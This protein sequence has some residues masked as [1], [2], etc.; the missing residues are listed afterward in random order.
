MKSLKK[1]VALFI[2]A[3]LFS[4]GAMPAL[5]AF[6][7]D[8][9]EFTGGDGHRY[10]IISEQ[11]KT[12]ALIGAAVGT[13]E[14]YNRE[15][16]WSWSYSG[17]TYDV[18]EIRLGVG[19]ANAEGIKNI[20]V[21]GVLYGRKK[22]TRVD[23]SGC[24][25]LV[26]LDC[27]LNALTELD[28]SSCTALVSLN[29]GGNALT[30]LDVSNCTALVSLD[31]GLNAL[32]ELDVS[33][34]K[35]L[36]YLSCAANAL[37]KLDVSENKALDYLWCG[38]NSIAELD[39]GG[40]GALRTLECERN[41]MTKLNMSGCM[42]LETLFCQDNSLKELDIVSGTKLINLTCS[43]NQLT[44]LDVS[45][46]TALKFLNCESN[47]IS[48]LDVST[49]INLTS[50][51]CGE[52]KLTSL[53]VTNNTSLGFLFCKSNAI[54]D[55]AG[56]VERMDAM[57]NF[58]TIPMVAKDGGYES[59]RQYELNKGSTIT[60][61]PS[62]GVEYDP[63]TKKF[64]TD[65]VATTVAFSTQNADYAEGLS[66]VS[67]V[68]S[69]MLEGEKP[70]VNPFA[71]VNE[72]DWFYPS[73]AFVVNNGLFNGTGATTFEPQG[74]MT[75]GSIVTVL[76]RMTGVDVAAYSGKSFDDVDM[77]VYYAPYIK[78]AAEKGIVNGTGNNKFEPDAEISRQDLSVILYNYI[79]K[80]GITIKQ[81]A[82]PRTGFYL[83]GIEEYARE[84]IVCLSG[85][86]IYGFKATDDF[87]PQG[88]ATR[89]EFAAM[90]ARYN[91]AI[92]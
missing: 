45:K 48:E 33:G 40:F 17:E 82:N 85:A 4:A 50:L 20:D 14:I 54:I 41:G 83:N 36:T 19:S 74:F 75:R 86:D 55:I 27:G 15:S 35:A 56:A 44:E 37:T 80:M 1:R 10:Q 52:N 68:I 39:V 24:T 43:D 88:S 63:A 5:P 6:A 72:G 26:T 87:D 42:S 8:G 78:W 49:N 21:N 51:N 25:G 22:L 89:A 81:Q 57:G 7:A 9:T 69:F 61:R 31:C 16:V 62:A 76:G 32:T 79:D 66:D 65:S 73:V 2:L 60:F 13:T 71:D 59:V 46:N 84:A 67:G 18:T 12:T 30:E 77:A 53:D 29:C 34:L 91:T 58:V 70:W 23:I 11:D 47:N 90:L 92:R 28:V 64:T 3:V 38:E